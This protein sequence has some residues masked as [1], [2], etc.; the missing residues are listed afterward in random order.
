MVE[1]FIRCREC[2]EILPV[3]PFSPEWESADWL[4]GIEWSAEDANLRRDFLSAHGSHPREELRADPETFFS[5]KPAFEAVKTSYFEATNGPERFLIR[6]TKPG[7]ASPARYEILPG[8]MEISSAAVEIQE[9]D[10]RRQII[11][12]RNPPAFDAG[13]VSAFIEAIREEIA[14]IPPRLLSEAIDETLEGDS[15]AFLFAALKE[16]RWARILERV[17]GCFEPPEREWVGGFI[18]RHR[19]PGEVLSLL[20]RRAFSVA[21]ADPPALPRQGFSN[22]RA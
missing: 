10:L 22:L 4:P 14:A 1:K 9:A 21:K 11:A 12:E 5:E 16:E 20:V 8:R 19:R 13:K 2:N 15:P 7:L 18:R 3:P 6:R 17:S